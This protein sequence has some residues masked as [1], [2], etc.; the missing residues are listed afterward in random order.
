MTRFHLYRI[1]K[2]QKMNPLSP[3]TYYRRHKRQTFL[4]VSLVALMTVGVCVMVRILDTIPENIVTAGNYLTHTSLVSSSSPELEAGVAAQIRAHPDVAHVI[5]EKGLALE[6]PAFFG[7]HHLFGVS[8]ADMQTILAVSGL[9]LK[10]G[11][12]PQLRT[13]EMALSE[14]MA[15]AMGLQIGDRIDRSIGEDWGGDNYYEA[16]P[17]PLK[18]VGILEEAGTGPQ[19]HL[20]FVSYEYV[21]NHEQ[22]TAPWTPGLVVI[23]QEGRQRE[24]EAFL[25]DEIASAQ[26]DVMTYQVLS[27]RAQGLSATFYAIFGVVDVLVAGVMAL[28]IG[29]INQITQAERLKEFGVLNALGHSKRQLTRRL[30]LETMFMTG[31]GWLAG[32]VLSW[33]LF[34]ILKGGFYASRGMDLSLFNLTPLWFS[35]PVPLVT[36]VFVALSTRRAFKRLDAVAIVERGQMS[37]ESAGQKQTVSRS[38]NKP[39]SSITFYVRHRRRGLVLVLTMSVMI[40]GVSFPAF[41]FAPMG[42]AMR[43]FAEPLRE[44]GIVTP[45]MGNAVD[46]GVTTQIKIHPTVDRVIPAAV[47]PLRVQI[48]P[49]GWQANFYGVTT[50]DMQVLVDL[51]G[52]E[53]VNGRFPQPRTN[54]IVLSEAV[55]RNRGW[56]I[57]DIVGGPDS[58]KDD[59]LPTEMVIVGILAPQNDGDSD[60]WLGFASSEFMSSHEQYAGVPAHLIVIPVDG[61]KAAMDT[62]LREEVHSDLVEVLTFDWMLHNFQLLTLIFLG[63]FG[64]VESVVAVIAAVAL[65]VLSYTFFRQRREEFGILHA[66]GHS[67]R[68]LVKRALRETVTV[69]SV[70]WLLSSVMCGIGLVFIQTGLYGPKGLTLNYFNPAPWL[71]TLPIPLVVIAVSAVTI[72]RML[73]KL[74]AVAIVERR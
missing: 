58:T 64:G 21:S 41:L 15:N 17:T 43:P 29:M 68:W 66:I 51:W 55:V 61:Q 69:V 46:P 54:E 40:L 39:L 45:R 67:R 1:E 49:L 62:W 23:A 56:Q 32:L 13:N 22:F 16:I 35:F 44:V 20:G 7:E 18:L 33:L 48:P 26:I 30:T 38:S 3:I 19:V 5:V 12:F 34:A 28:V 10:D 8:E 74:D 65:A 42:D 72:A 71:F 60:P 53:V 14:E 25:E 36:T 4:L 63:V 70:A 9:R 6:L 50:D 27:K 73:S 2:T 52:M 47:L 11:R 31:M 59:Y 37:T 57:G 24:V